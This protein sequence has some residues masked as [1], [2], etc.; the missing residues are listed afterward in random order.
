MERSSF[1]LHVFA[2]ADAVLAALA[3]YFVE[4]A[5]Q[6]VAARGRFAKRH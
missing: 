6:A 3:D 1:N 2:D 5:S 4:Q